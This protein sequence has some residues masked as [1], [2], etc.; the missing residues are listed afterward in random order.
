MEG[1]RGGTDDEGFRDDLLRDLERWRTYIESMSPPTAETLALAVNDWHDVIEAAEEYR[2]LLAAFQADAANMGDAEADARMGQA[3]AA[4]ARLM[5]CMKRFDLAAQPPLETARL[6]PGAK[7]V[8]DDRTPRPFKTMLADALARIEADMLT[9]RGCLNEAETT[10]RRAANCRPSAKPIVGAKQQ[11]WTDEATEYMLLSEAIAK[12]ADGGI[13]LKGASKKI[14][15]S[16]AVRFMRKGRR[17]KVNIVDFIQW[18]KAKPV[19]EAEI[20]RQREE[21]EK[22]KAAERTRRKAAGG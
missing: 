10:A 3:E 20:D 4:H 7:Y 6:Y 2:A 17:C 15:D 14:T 22:R 5:T 16:G 19:T 18:W 9:L 1:T 8:N 21:I 12:L 13:T 11:P